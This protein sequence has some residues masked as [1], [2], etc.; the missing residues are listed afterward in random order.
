MDIKFATGE[1]TIP[2]CSHFIITKM[3]DETNDIR[4]LSDGEQILSLS[5]HGDAESLAESIKADG[6]SVEIRLQPSERINRACPD[7]R[8]Q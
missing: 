6:M 5:H 2:K 7:Q 8:W 4:V 1:I 3:I